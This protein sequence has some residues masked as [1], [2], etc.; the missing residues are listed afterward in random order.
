[1]R[2]TGE[3]TV[4]VEDFRLCT[5]PSFDF[6]DLPILT[7]ERIFLRPFYSLWALPETD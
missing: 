5:L 7:N 4:G 3:D 2:L 1:M 6:D